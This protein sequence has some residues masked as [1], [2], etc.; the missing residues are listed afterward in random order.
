LQKKVGDSAGRVARLLKE[1][2]AVPQLVEELYLASLG[3]K[4]DAVETKSAIESVAQ[5]G[6]LREGAEDLLWALLNC[7]EFQFNH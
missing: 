4:P 5:A 3:R 7:R 6:N 1:K 2:V